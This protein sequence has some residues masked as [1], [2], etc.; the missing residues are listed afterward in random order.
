MHPDELVAARDPV[1]L[2]LLA[3]YQGFPMPNLRLDDG[4][5]AAVLSYLDDASHPASPPRR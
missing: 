1:G 3:R 2:A 5:T 4:E